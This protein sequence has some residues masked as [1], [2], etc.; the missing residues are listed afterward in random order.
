MIQPPGDRG[1]ACSEKFDVR[2]FHAV[3]LED[4]SVPLDILERK[5]DRWI[6][7]EKGWGSRQAARERASRIAPPTNSTMIDSMPARVLS[8]RSAVIPTIAGPSTAA[9]LPIML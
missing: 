9:N 1:R 6:A 3:V 5:V 2:K 7:G 8:V 4:G